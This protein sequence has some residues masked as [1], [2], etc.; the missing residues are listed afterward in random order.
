MGEMQ[1][2]ALQI[3]DR[4]ERLCG[5]TVDSHDEA[6]IWTR[7][8]GSGQDG[9][10]LNQCGPLHA[11]ILSGFSSGQAARRLFLKRPA[12]TGEAPARG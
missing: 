4:R 11:E 5:A 9:R 8:L 7:S 10:Q 1:R 12:W 6:R 3:E 2:V